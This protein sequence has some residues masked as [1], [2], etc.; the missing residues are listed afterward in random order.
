MNL[1]QFEQHLIEFAKTESSYAWPVKAEDLPALVEEYFDSFH[2]DQTTHQCAQ[3][4]LKES[5]S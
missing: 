2:C 4:F 5:Q 3:Q 1:E